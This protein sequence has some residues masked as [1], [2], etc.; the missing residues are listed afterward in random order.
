VQ[1]RAGHAKASI[2]ADVYGHAMAR[3]QDE[4]A[5][6]IEEMV[7]IIAVRGQPKIF[8]NQPTTICGDPKNI[9]KPY[10]VV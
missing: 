2:T 5:Q 6:K 7:L 9:Y 1:R 10:M 8:M 3:S 4:A